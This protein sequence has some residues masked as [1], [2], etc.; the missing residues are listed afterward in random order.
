MLIFVRCNLVNAYETHVYDQSHTQ[1]LPT[2][3]IDVVV[4]NFIE[5]TKPHIDDLVEKFYIDLVVLFLNFVLFF[6]FWRNILAKH[7]CVVLERFQV[8]DFMFFMHI[9]VD[10]DLIDNG[11]LNDVM[12][13]QVVSSYLYAATY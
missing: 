11:M 12:E 13:V 9:N 4:D 10:I 2:T 8:M 1:D 6:L 3:Y 7:Q 5:G